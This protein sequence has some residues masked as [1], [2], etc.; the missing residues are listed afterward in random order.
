MDLFLNEL[1]GDII[2]TTVFAI[3]PILWWVITARRKENFFKWIGLKK[4]QPQNTRKFFIFT[5]LCILFF[6]SFGTLL[7]Y[8]TR[9]I[10]NVNLA[11]SKFNGLKFIG[12][13]AALVYAFLGT[14][15]PEEIF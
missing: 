7:L 5:G 6:V 3:I 13:P 1:L 12:L 8:M 10:S 9:D 4:I 14:A 11:T 15:L 2:Q